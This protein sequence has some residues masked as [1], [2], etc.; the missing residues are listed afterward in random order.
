MI[1]YGS[2]YTDQF[3][4]VFR[5][6]LPASSQTRCAFFDAADVFVRGF[7]LHLDHAGVEEGVQIRRLVAAGRGGRRILLRLGANI[8]QAGEAVHHRSVVIGE[9]SERSQPIGD[10][11]VH[12]GVEVL[13]RDLVALRLLE[14][15]DSAFGLPVGHVSRAERCGVVGAVDL[16]QLV[17]PFGEAV[18]RVF[19]RVV[20][21]EHE[22]VVGARGEAHDPT[23]Q[24]PA[25]GVW[26]DVA[27][28]VVPVQ[29][30]VLGRGDDLLRDLALDRISQSDGRRR[31]SRGGDEAGERYQGG[32]GQQGQQGSALT[33]GSSGGWTTNL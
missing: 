12:G 23:R 2:P 16:F 33:H 21:H 26:L 5:L 19:C 1:E 10:R 29:R 9:L 13:H 30:G 22:H 3:S 24:T 27:V 15:G 20:L 25:V 17:D 8:L 6:R 11:E 4:G 32:G 31:L 7:L 18:V 28:L 14:R